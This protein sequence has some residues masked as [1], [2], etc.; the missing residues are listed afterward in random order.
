MAKLMSQAEQV[1]FNAGI[2]GEWVNNFRCSC[3]QDE[4]RTGCE[5]SFNAALD[6]V[7]ALL[8]KKETP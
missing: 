1:A 3:D 2:P 8:A 5:R 4:C 7:L 6:D